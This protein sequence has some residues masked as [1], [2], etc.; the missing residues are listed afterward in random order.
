MRIKDKLINQINE[1]YIYLAIKM[2]LLKYYNH[3]KLN[4]EAEGG[5]I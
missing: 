5:K 2:Y 1:F 4:E 3:L